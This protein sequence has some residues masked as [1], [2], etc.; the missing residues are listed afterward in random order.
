MTVSRLY[1]VFALAFALAGFPALVRAEEGVSKIDRQRLVVH[2]E[3]T[4]D[5]LQEQ[6]RGLSEAQYRFRA[7][8][9]SWSVLDV[10]EHLAIAEPQYW[11][12]LQK[13]LEAAPGN[14]KRQGTDADMLWY[15]ID[16]TRRNKT[17]EARTPSGKYKTLAE[18]LQSFLD[19]REKQLAFARTTEKDL[20][21]YQ[22]GPSL[23]TYL[24]F[25]MISS[26]SER[27]IHQ[28]REIKANAA[29]PKS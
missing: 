11:T 3:M 25:L 29:F 16:R 4:R 8:P 21:N 14:V 13:A 24:W 6:V 2:L 15:G 10:V 5:M 27:H 7:T 12:D 26:H 17:A 19:L 20:R 22:F 28:I 1:L 9:E 18:A 23:D